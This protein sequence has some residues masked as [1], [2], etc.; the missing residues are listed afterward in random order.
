MP[1]EIGKSWTEIFAYALPE[2]AHTKNPH[3]CCSACRE[4]KELVCVCRCGGKN[5]AAA[6]RKGMEP[7][8]K[9][10]GLE[11]EAPAPLGDLA[12]SRELSGLAELEGEI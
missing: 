10:L 7:L 9:V 4:A 11:K 3:E 5:H 2:R 12:L 6:L 1:T 8:D